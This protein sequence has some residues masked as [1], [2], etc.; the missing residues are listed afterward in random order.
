[1]PPMVKRSEHEVGR[2][3]GLWRYPVKSM[4]E[5]SLDA[6]DV[7]WHG[8]AGDRRWAFI[9]DGMP[10]S[11]F[12]WL[13]I[14]EL[15]QMRHYLPFFTEPERPED[16]RTMVRTP[17]GDELEVI[18]P[19]LAAELGDGVRLIKQSVGVFDTMPLSLISTQTIAS[20]AAWV[21]PTLTPERFRPNLLVEATGQEAF[22][23]DAWLGSVL[24]IGELEMRVDRR[25]VRCV[26]INID[27]ETDEKDPDVL[28]SVARERETCLAVYGTTVTPGRV[29]VGDAVTVER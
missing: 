22:P 20:L 4:A 13:T 10:R 14:R 2:V 7:S 17:G 12:P 3:V 11:G 5:E 24:R 19:A 6:V 21:A 28:R 25:D 23:E 15:P 27:P 1:M 9:Q 29:A 18:D 8:L 16:S 26:M